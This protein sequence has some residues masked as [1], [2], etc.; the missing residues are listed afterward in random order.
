MKKY[1]LKTNAATNL[2]ES[3]RVDISGGEYVVNSSG[4]YVIYVSGVV[5]VIQQVM[6]GLCHIYII[7]TKESAEAQIFM[8]GE[9]DADADIYHSITAKAERV[10]A[11]VV[12][13][14]YVKTGETIYRSICIDSGNVMSVLQDVSFL[15]GQRGVVISEPALSIDNNQSTAKHSV[16]IRK[17]DEESLYFVGSCGISMAEAYNILTQAFIR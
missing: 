12:G 15:R 2:P 11:R 16:S 4:V 14:V 13:R 8:K 7:L 6:S 3:V 5:R 10:S 17:I 9:L 1:G